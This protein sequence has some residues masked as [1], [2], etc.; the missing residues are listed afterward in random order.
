LK[1]KIFNYSNLDNPTSAF[2][3]QFTKKEN[4]VYLHLF[5][6]FIYIYG[7]YFL[8]KINILKFNKKQF[9]YKKLSYI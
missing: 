9:Y 1:I 5:I 4:D 2:N 6:L 8:I 3:I 7:I